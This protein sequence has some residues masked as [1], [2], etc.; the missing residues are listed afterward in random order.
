M[1]INQKLFE[2]T[3]VAEL[4]E[5]FRN[6]KPFQA[7]SAHILSAGYPLIVLRDFL[8]DR[9]ARELKNEVLSLPFKHKA[10]DLFDFF[11]SPDLKSFL[12][13][14]DS[15]I[16]RVCQEIFSQN[17][18]S[19]IGKI[20][21]KPLG[22][23][24]DFAAQK[25]CKGQYLLCHDDRLES[26]RVAFVLYLVD[27][28][29]TEHDGGQFDKYGLDF[30]GAPTMEPVESFTPSWNTLV[31][32]EV[33]MWSHHQVAEVLGVLP[34]ISV[35]GWLHDFPSQ[36]DH[37]DVLAIP[38]VVSTPVID[39]A[40]S[41][42]V[43][44][45]NITTITSKF[46]RILLPDNSSYLLNLIKPEHYGLAGRVDYPTWPTC[47]RLDHTS[48]FDEPVVALDDCERL[49]AVSLLSSPARVK[50]ND[51]AIREGQT[52]IFKASQG[53]NRIHI[54]HCLDDD[55]KCIFIYWSFLLLK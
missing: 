31:F 24:V 11:Q 7:G 19:T 51:L 5:Y 10:T 52:T 21:G 26:R 45:D 41:F 1:V 29:W 47:V 22:T 4:G 13:D 16:S 25:Y 15:P 27:E 50:V 30:R 42:D 32:F 38:D 17:F 9:F 14:Q 55:Q 46:T 43:P 35:A 44:V 40:V 54:A 3:L 49:V 8:D 2:P 33:S 6:R 23:E 36:A 39:Q 12:D 37:L 34:R 53:S 20:V 28:S 18:T 48:H